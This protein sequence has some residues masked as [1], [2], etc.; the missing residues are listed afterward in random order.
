[1]SIP[2]VLIHVCGGVAD[3]AVFGDVEIAY[4]DEDNIDAG[5]PPV[6]LDSTWRPVLEGRF[7]IPTS[8]Y[9][10]ITEAEQE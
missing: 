8:K 1:M 5:D 2:K 3:Y 7:N 6:E 9:V 4:V 10:T